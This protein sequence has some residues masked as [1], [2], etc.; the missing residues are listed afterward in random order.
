VFVLTS[1]TSAPASLA[2]FAA[3]L[4]ISSVLPCSWLL[5]VV[6][7]ESHAHRRTFSYLAP[8]SRD[9]ASPA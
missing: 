4:A 2:P 1:V 3:A 8:R 9:S 6:E 5:G 7:N